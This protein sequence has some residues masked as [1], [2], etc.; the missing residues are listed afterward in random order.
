MDQ[1]MVLKLRSL[2]VAEPICQNC[3]ADEFKYYKVFMGQVLWCDKCLLQLRENT[4]QEPS[5]LSL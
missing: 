4:C 3:L 1:D 5:S 2:G